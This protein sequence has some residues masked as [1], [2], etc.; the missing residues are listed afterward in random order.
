MMWMLPTLLV[1]LSVVAIRLHR[2]AT[3]LYGPL[4]GPRHRPNHS[5]CPHPAPLL[6]R[7]R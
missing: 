5:L 1:A 3:R 6:S 4:L 7:H 2:R